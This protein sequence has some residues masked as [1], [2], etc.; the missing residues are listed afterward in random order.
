MTRSKQRQDLEKLKDVLDG[1]DTAMFTTVAGDGRL[2]SRPL[3]MQEIDE[4]GAMWF[5]TDRHSHKIDELA[6]RP[7]VNV[8]FAAPSDNTYVSI[9]GK[10]TV[11]FDKARLNQLWSPAMTV[12]YPDGVDDPDLCL[13]RVDMDGAEYWNSPGGVVGN[14]LY[15][16]MAAITGEAGV[17]SENRSMELGDPRSR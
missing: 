17:L 2:V 16:A 1:I 10:A 8:A 11:L 6:A 3:R 7:R 4:D 13:L 5:V 14:A 9:S 12:F 15:L